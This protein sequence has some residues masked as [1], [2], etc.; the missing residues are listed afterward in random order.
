MIRA[1][2]ALA[3]VAFG[4][5]VLESAHVPTALASAPP[6]TTEV[7]AW[8]R[9]APGNGPVVV[10]PLGLDINSTPAMV[11]SLEHRRP[12]V[13][14]YSGQR[15]SFYAPLVDTLSTFPSDESLLALH[16]LGVQ[17][18]VSPAALRSSRRHQSTIIAAS[19]STACRC[20]SSVIGTTW[21]GVN[22]GRSTPRLG[23]TAASVSPAAPSSGRPF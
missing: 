20:C 8:L 5:V 21:G 15:P 17:Y 7:G 12:L 23:T 22:A 4:A 11:Q 3:L 13:N 18:V 1:Y 9:Q 10:L 14:G 2:Q 6:G 19:T 16:E